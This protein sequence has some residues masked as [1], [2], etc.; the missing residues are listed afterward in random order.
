MWGLNFA[1]LQRERRQ[2]KQ[3]LEDRSLAHTIGLYAAARQGA[4]N[5]NKFI[6]AVDRLSLTEEDRF[7][8][9]EAELRATL[10]AEQQLRLHAALEL[11]R[12][13]GRARRSQNGVDWLIN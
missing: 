11:M 3:D 6:S 8:V 2:A 7:L 12:K 13:D 4:L 10:P 9:T 5:N 1:K